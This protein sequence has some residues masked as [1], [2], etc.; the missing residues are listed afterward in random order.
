MLRLKDFT[1]NQKGGA[2]ILFAVS[3]TVLIGF[4]A[5]AVDVGNFFY[6][7]RKLQTA[8][9]LAA[10][11]AASDLPRAQAAAQASAGQ[12]GFTG[13]TIQALQTGMYTP[14]PQKA[15]E[16]RFV[17]SSPTVA[18]AVRIDMRTTTPLL[19]GRVLASASTTSQTPGTAPPPAGGTTVASLSGG[20]VPIGSSAIAFQDAQASFAVGSR[21]LKL[22]GGLLN[23]L[24]GGLLGGGVSLSVMDYDAL[25]KARVDLFDFSKRLATRLNL[26]AATY[27]DV[28]KAN[29]RLGDVLAAVVDASRDHD[30]RNSTATAALGRIAA[31]SASNLPVNLASLISFGPAGDKP[32]S[33]PK[34][35]AASLTALDIVSAVAQIANG[36]RQIDVGLA[37]NLPGIAAA[38]LKLGIGERPVGTSMVRVGRAGASVHTAQTRLLLTVDL[39]GSGAASLVRLPLYLELAAATARL[40]GIQCSPGDVSTSRVTLGVT[41]ALVDAWIGQ[42]SMAE[43][44]N[45]SRAPNPPAATL[46]NVAGLAKVSGRAHVTM[47]NLSEATVSFSYPEVQRGDKKTTSTQNFVATL[48]GRLVGDLELRVEALGLG[49][50]LPGLDGLVSGVIAGAATP[51]DQVLNGVLGTLGIGLGQA[52]SWVTGVRCGGAVLVR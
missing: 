7:K 25:I 43:F 18:N 35:L 16:A 28:L 12:N 32:L 21:L 9:D 44:N 52:D 4:G 38:S 33:G 1:R 42:V 47:T 29:V 6:E 34:P 8:N 19:L 23:S 31:A 2:A 50:G 40:T 48:L 45:F 11:A 49:I 41:P 20:D 37:L 13:S 17:P 15:P 36:N 22:D 26:T 10:L 24:L 14:D 30:T 46:L 3:A 27:D 5:M 39:V 51:L